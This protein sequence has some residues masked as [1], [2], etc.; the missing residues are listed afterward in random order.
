MGDQQQQHQRIPVAHHVVNVKIHIP[1]NL[2][3]SPPNYTAWRELF[4][5]LVSYFSLKTHLDG[6]K[7]PGASC[8][9]DLDDFTVVSWL[10]SMI[11][12][13]I[14][15]IVLSPGATAHMIWTSIDD[16]FCNNKKMFSGT[17]QG[18]LPVL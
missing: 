14:L 13:E 18:D 8:N 9:W 15:G 17:A 10:Y 11:S 2:T 3:L 6:P 1:F 7:P 12:E 4:L 5:V 16:L